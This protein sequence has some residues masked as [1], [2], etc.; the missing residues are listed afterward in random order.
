MVYP[1]SKKKHWHSKWDSQLEQRF[2]AI[3]EDISRRLQNNDRD[4][5]TCHF[6]ER[7]PVT[8]MTRGLCEKCFSYQRYANT[9]H[10]WPKVCY[11]KPHLRICGITHCPLIHYA[12]N[13]C[14]EHFELWETGQEVIKVTPLTSCQLPDC[15]NRHLRFGLCA[16]HV[17]H[18]LKGRIQL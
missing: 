11:G 17:R 7:E 2:N 10:R 8:K 9:L 15:N 12:N 16:K 6:C 4:G 3:A 1:H 18:L 13:Q 5:W 14:K